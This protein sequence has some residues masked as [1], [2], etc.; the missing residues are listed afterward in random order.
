[1]ARLVHLRDSWAKPL[2]EM[3]GVQLHTSLKTGFACG[4]ANVTIEGIAPADLA[5]YLWKERRIFTVPIGHDECPGIRVSPSVYTTPEEIER[6][7]EAMTH[8]AK[9]GVATAEA[10]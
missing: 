5:A 7:V 6:F 4:I 10:D 2:L 3:D 8:A 1:M 9:H